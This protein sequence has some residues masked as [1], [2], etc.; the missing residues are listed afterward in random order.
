M[1]PAGAPYVTPMHLCSLLLSPLCSTLSW[2][3]TCLLLFLEP[4]YLPSPP[5]QALR[6]LVSNPSLRLEAPVVFLLNGG[7]EVRSIARVKAWW[8]VF[9]EGARVCVW[10]GWN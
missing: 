8:H 9:S 1:A 6:V 3:S 7:E 2:Q 4:L 5:P 10:G